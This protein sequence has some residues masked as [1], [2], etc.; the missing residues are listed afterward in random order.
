MDKHPFT[1][2][3]LD[4]GDQARVERKLDGYGLTWELEESI[5]VTPSTRELRYLV[6]GPPEALAHLGL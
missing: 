5:Q 4:A 1:T 3:T 6:S 2:I